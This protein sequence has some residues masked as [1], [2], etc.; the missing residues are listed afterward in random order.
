MTCSPYP[1]LTHCLMPLTTCTWLNI[2]PKTQPSHSVFRALVTGKTPH[3]A[4]SREGSLL[5]RKKKTH[6]APSTCLAEETGQEKAPQRCHT[7]EPGGLHLRPFCIN[8]RITW[9]LKTIS[10]SS[11]YFRHHKGSRGW[12]EQ[13]PN[14][15]KKTKKGSRLFSLQNRPLK[16]DH[17]SHMPCEYFCYHAK[18]QTAN[19][20]TIH[21]TESIQAVST[22]GMS[23]FASRR[24]NQ[25]SES[26]NHKARLLLT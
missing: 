1:I 8:H 10:V 12:Q 2:W 6:S 15:G 18:N 26:S 11:Q 5:C 9:D 3:V 25:I 21:L 7:Y 22:A 13:S 19:V 14:L 24:G 4:P 20:K 16:A 17:I 23:T